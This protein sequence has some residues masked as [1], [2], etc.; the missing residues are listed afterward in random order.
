MNEHGYPEISDDTDIKAYG[1][2]LVKMLDIR[3]KAKMK[4]L[5]EM[6]FM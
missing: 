6:E 2:T 1:E 5:L 4:L 3:E